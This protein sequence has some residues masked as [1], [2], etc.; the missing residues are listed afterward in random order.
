MLDAL[1]DREDREVTGARETPV[2]EER[3]ETAQHPGGA[4]AGRKDP[5]DE[6]RA[7]KMQLR[8]RDR[9]ALVCEQVPGVVSQDGLELAERRRRSG[10]HLLLL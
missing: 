9:F 6:V 7:G 4:V 3:F 8:L 10:G 2:V 1:V 5:G